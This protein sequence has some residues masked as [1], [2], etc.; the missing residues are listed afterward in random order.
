MGAYVDGL[1]TPARVR[2]AAWVV[3]GLCVVAAVLNV[4][5]G[6][7]P[8]T[9]IGTTFLPDWFAHWTGG[10][11]LLDGHASDLYDPAVQQALQDSVTGGLPVLA[12]FV[13]PPVAG[14]VYVP[15]AA[16][17][18]VASGV[19]W[20][21]VT[22][23]LLVAS[24]ALLR[25]LLPTYTDQ[26]WRLALLCVA[27]SQPV[28][29]LVGGGQDSALLLLVW[30]AGL[31]LLHAHRDLA[32]GAVLALG[33]VKPQLFVLVP[34]VLLVQR[35]WSALGAWVAT[36]LAL[37]GASLAVGGIDGNR[38][39][40]EALTSDRYHEV[41]QIGQSW[42]MHGVPSALV[43]LVPS[44]YAGVA[45][46]VGLALG[47]V[48]VVAMLLVVRRTPQATVSATWSLVALT[49]VLL[50]PHILSYD[51]VLLIP[52]V[53]HLA[54]GGGT[55]TTRLSLL[56]LFLLTWTAW[57]RHELAALSPWLGWVGVS[58]AVVPLLVLW[59]EAYRDLGAAASDSTEVDAAA[60]TQVRIAEATRRRAGADVVWM[61]G[62]LL[63]PGYLVGELLGDAWLWVA[64]ASVLLIVV[65]GVLR[66]R[67]TRAIWAA[68]PDHAP[69]PWKR[70]WLM[71]L[72]EPERKN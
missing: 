50:T 29:E 33:L 31:R 43:S 60:D 44:S 38:A 8:G 54:R 4:A 39:W 56:A 53:L 67:Q 55:R 68:D 15:F 30:V 37:V 11:M 35:R 52:A 2:V 64:A 28:L 65:G 66:A 19:V 23:A 46:W 6:D 71:D 40:V 49:T 17:P 41:V 1:L 32:A 36:T 70:T 27:A 47:A 26:Q 51:L 45:Q 5:L 24:A 62:L 59:R 18:Y 20:A 22:I 10:R 3:V 16:L 58:W 61:L 13:S 57:P 25:P 9:A 7:L 34:L 42:M 63:M 69:V 72:D 12:W 48:L 21:A 14:L